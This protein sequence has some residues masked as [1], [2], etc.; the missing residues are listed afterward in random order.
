LKKLLKI[1]VIND[2]ELRLTYS[3]ISPYDIYLLATPRYSIYKPELP[4][5]GSGPWIFSKQDGH[6]F[7]FH[8]FPSSNQ[9][10]C[11]K[12]TAVNL[13]FKDAVNELKNGKLDIIEYISLSKSELEFVRNE[14]KLVADIHA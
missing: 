5:I 3:S 12:L 8:A 11:R 9:A 1:E 14:T 10:N 7:K 6:R 4:R 2:K 13:P